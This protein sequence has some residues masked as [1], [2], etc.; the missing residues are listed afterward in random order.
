MHVYYRY[1]SVHVQN[2]NIQLIENQRYWFSINSILILSD[3]FILPKN[4]IFLILDLW[5][6]NH[7]VFLFEINF[8]NLWNFRKLGQFMILD[9]DEVETISPSYIEDR[10]LLIIIIH[11][12]YNNFTI[13]CIFP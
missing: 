13:Y 5:K 11:L 12:L 6:E 10:I 7:D 8:I 3:Q 9:A 4:S 1:V 2:Y